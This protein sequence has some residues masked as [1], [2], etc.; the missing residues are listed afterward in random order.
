[1]TFSARNLNPL[2]ILLL[3]TLHFF[4]IQAACSNNKETD[5]KPGGSCIQCHPVELDKAHAFS[6]SN[7][8]NGNEN[9]K[10]KEL[11]H[12]GLISKPAHPDHAEASCASCHSELVAGTAHNAHYLLPSYTSLI[13][14]TIDDV[15]SHP[16]H[17]HSF[18]EPSSG[19]ELLQDALTRK[20]LRCHVYHSGDDFP[21][22][23]RATGCGACHLE[24]Y[25]GAMVSHRFQKRPKDTACL[26][27][28]YGNRVGFDYYGYFEHDLNEEY[29]TPYTTRKAFFRPYGVEYHNLEADVHKR[30]GLV[31]VDCHHQAQL[32]GKPGKRAEC[33]SCHDIN[34][35]SD[36]TAGAT[37]DE[38]NSYLYL[39]PATGKS[40]KLPLM[41]HPA[42]LQY[43]NRVSCQA[44][45]AQWS[46]K[47]NQTHLLRI[48]HDD[49]DEFEKLTLDGDSHVHHVLFS[50]IDFDSEI[51]AVST[52]HYLTGESFPGIWVQG[53]LE[54]RWENTDLISGDDG[55][56]H[57]SRPMLDLYLSWIDREE[58]IRF[59]NFRPIATQRPA[60]PYIP[61]T[62]GRA[63]AFFRQKLSPFLDNQEHPRTDS[64]D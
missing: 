16:Y 2:P 54:R 23:R 14:D 15:V 27:C 42:H 10:T 7:C 55:I 21:L 32:M 13:S 5:R 41:S 30:A 61:H 28:H 44:C 43:Q 6:C 11:A 46:F 20:C 47:D 26:S 50:N 22:T 39:S 19:T 58:F 9:K 62:I 56:I 59:D 64:P 18:A 40:F 3:L 29:R 24:Y 51:Q 37:K 25:D 8:H 31:C 36:G 17:L 63:D 35:L 45:H 53:Y 38:N 52:D 57:V 33:R 1:M 49:F 48:D 34:F 4:L 60:L 12:V